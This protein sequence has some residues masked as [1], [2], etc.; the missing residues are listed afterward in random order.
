LRGRRYLQQASRRAPHYSFDK[1]LYNLEGSVTLKDPQGNTRRV[2]AGDIV[3]FSAGSRAEWTVQGYIRKLTFCRT[4]M[5]GY[6]V[7]ARNLARRL[8]RLI[9]DG[10]AQGIA[11]GMFPSG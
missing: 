8:K 1:T 7:L 9:R 3:Y 5:P 4:A 10:A 2:V 6:L 11:G